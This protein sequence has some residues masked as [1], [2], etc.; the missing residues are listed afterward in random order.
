MEEHWLITVKSL[1][2]SSCL[3]FSLHVTASLRSHGVGAFVCIVLKW[4]EEQVESSDDWGVR[5]DT[6]SLVHIH[7]YMLHFRTV[8]TFML[9]Y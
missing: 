1:E 8:E 5:E 2:E 9:F 6:C 7:T 3:I 4:R